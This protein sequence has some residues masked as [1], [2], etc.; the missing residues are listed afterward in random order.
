MQ[1]TC[2]LVYLLLQSVEMPFLME[3][4]S[5]SQP[6]HTILVL[7]A[8]PIPAHL[9]EYTGFQLILHPQIHASKNSPLS[10]AVSWN[11]PSV[12]ATSSCQWMK[13]HICQNPEEESLALEG[14]AAKSARAHPDSEKD[15]GWVHQPWAQLKCGMHCHTQQWCEL[16]SVLFK[17]RG[18]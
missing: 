10:P 1:I 2:S 9:L 18:N 15:M 14:I 3:S 4:L 6:P 17:K 12:S 13:F 7:P 16:C 11:N 5:V 8:L